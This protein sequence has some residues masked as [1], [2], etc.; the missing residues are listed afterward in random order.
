MPD[1][2]ADLHHHLLYGLD[3]GAESLDVTPIHIDRDTLTDIRVFGPF[4]NPAGTVQTQLCL[5][6]TF[7]KSR[8]QR[9]ENTVWAVSNLLG[10]IRI[11][12]YIALDMTAISALNDALGGVRVTLDEDF[13]HL[14]PAMVRGVTLTLQG[15]QAE[16]FV[17]GRYGVGDA[18]NRGRMERQ[19]VFVEAA[20]DLFSAQ[21]DEDPTFAGVL[22]DALSGH[23][24]ASIDR[25]WLINHSYAFSHY[26]RA[27]IQSLP[28]THAVGEDG[29]MAF[30]P[31]HPAL[32]T[33]L[34]DVFYQELSP[35]S[36]PSPKEVLP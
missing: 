8:Q 17:R 2:Y 1:G 33:L 12:E 35:A 24:C 19:R 4:G 32:G 13:S 16:H 10:G 9:C 31:D 14:D 36:T 28:G 18:T 11:D 30:T 3:D 26:R 22:Y 29:F 25:T 5:S 7:G 15:R 23:L 34:L 21:L 27:P 20:A 6:H